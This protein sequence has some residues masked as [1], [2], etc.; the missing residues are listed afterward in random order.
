MKI[1]DDTIRTISVIYGDNDFP[2]TFNPLLETII[3]AIE[4]RGKELTKNDIDFLI[5]EGFRFHYM[6]FQMRFN[7]DNF[8]QHL[9]F[10]VKYFKSNIKILFDEEAEFDIENNDHDCGASYVVLCEGIVNNY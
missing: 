8:D 9:D 10:L 2:H 4:F 6:A 7:K 1:K 3:R 5:R